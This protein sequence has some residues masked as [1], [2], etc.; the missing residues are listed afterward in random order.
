MILTPDPNTLIP[1]TCCEIV[2]KRSPAYIP[3]RSFV[4]FV[5]NETSPRF[6]RP[7]A[8]GFVRGAGEEQSGGSGRNR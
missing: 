2:A 6:E 7:Q 4:A 5:N 8:N 3:N 1:A